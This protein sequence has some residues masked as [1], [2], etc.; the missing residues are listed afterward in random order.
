MYKTSFD[1]T[2]NSRI[3]LWKIILQV[4]PEM[5]LKVSIQYAVATSNYYL[6]K[7]KTDKCDF[8]IIKHYFVIKNDKLW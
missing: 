1:V 6:V 8:F 2:V 4:T 3:A 7:R 5:L